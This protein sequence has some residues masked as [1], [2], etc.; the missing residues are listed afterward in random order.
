MNQP[1]APWQESERDATVDALVRG[2]IAQ[3]SST[4][5]DGNEVVWSLSYDKFREQY[6]YTEINDVTT[7]LDRQLGTFD[8]EGKLVVSN[9]ETGTTWDGFGRSFHSRV[10]IVDITDDG[11][12]VESESSIDGG[13]NWFLALKEA[14]TRSGE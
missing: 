6:V 13:E 5:A 1:G 12:Q 7:Y 9:V 11:F 4:T 2:A 8:E 14:Y 10:S 3:E